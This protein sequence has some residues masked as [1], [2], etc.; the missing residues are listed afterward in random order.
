MRTLITSYLS[1][2]YN[3][4]ANNVWPNVKLSIALQVQD[5]TAATSLMRDLH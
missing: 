5:P 1:Y 4:V 3:P 2:S